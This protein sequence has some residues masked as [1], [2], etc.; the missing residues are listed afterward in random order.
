MHCW[1]Y[2]FKFQYRL[3]K[4]YGPKVVTET[5]SW[6]GKYI[7]ITNN[8]IA[9]TEG[10]SLKGHFQGRETDRLF[11]P[12]MALGLDMSHNFWLD[13]TMYICWVVHYIVHKSTYKA[14]ARIA[15]LAIFYWPLDGLKVSMIDTL[16]SI[17]L[18]WSI[19]LLLK[20]RKK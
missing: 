7:L 12:N 3:K 6:W 16:T 2:F 4:W 11:Y 18:F 17:T 10:M 9:I 14:S 13:C 20:G 1:N 19:T 15:F 5:I 8:I